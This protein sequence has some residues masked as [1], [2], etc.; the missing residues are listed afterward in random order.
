MSGPGEK[1]LDALMARL[2]DGD[3]TAFDPLFSALHPRALALAR[4]RLDAN[5]ADDA[6]AQTL[7]R[8]FARAAEFTP[9]RPLLPWFYAIA[10]NEVHTLARRH[11]RAQSRTADVALADGIAAPVTP[12]TALLES[13]LRACLR[14]A[15]GELDAPSAE[16]IRALLDGTERPVLGDAAFRKRV[17]RAYARLRVILGGRS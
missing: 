11:S 2:V 16:A 5:D 7:M 13:E 15:V 3:R 12:E 10:A 1:E 14:S 8:L 9:G 4:L 17:S 6:A